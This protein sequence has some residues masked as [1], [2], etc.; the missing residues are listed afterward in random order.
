MESILNSSIIICKKF[1]TK[2]EKQQLGSRNCHQNRNSLKQTCH[3]NKSYTVPTFILV[4]FNMWLWCFPTTQAT[5]LTLPN[6]KNPNL[7]MA[8]PIKKETDFGKNGV[9]SSQLFYLKLNISYRT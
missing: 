4:I 8:Q 9:L 1:I 6:L 5:P 7:Y 3:Y 2:E